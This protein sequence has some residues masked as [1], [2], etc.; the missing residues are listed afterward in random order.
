MEHKRGEDKL[1]NIYESSRHRIYNPGR[2][3]DNTTKEA[4]WR[5][6]TMWQL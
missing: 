4:V 2:R 3:S 1:W 5:S 6:G